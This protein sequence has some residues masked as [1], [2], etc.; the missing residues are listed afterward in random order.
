M[1]SSIVEQWI[2]S[3]PMALSAS[4]FAYVAILGFTRTERSW[5]RVTVAALLCLC[6]P[7]VTLFVA[8]PFLFGIGESNPRSI[9]WAIVAVVLSLP[10][11]TAQVAILPNRKRA[12]FE[13]LAYP[14]TAVLALA[15]PPTSGH[16]W[17]SMAD[18]SLFALWPKTLAAAPFAGLAAIAASG[19]SFRQLGFALV[20]VLAPL[21]VLKGVT[22]W[23]HG[24][25][26]RA[27]IWP[28]AVRSRFIG[29]DDRL[30]AWKQAHEGISAGEPVCIGDHWYRFENV[31][32]NG[33]GSSTS[34]RPGCLTNVALA[35]TAD[36]LGIASVISGRV[37]VLLFV[38][39]TAPENEL[40]RTKLT[41]AEGDLIVRLLPPRDAHVPAKQLAF[42][43][44][45]L[46]QFIRDARLKAP[47]NR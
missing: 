7:V 24:L 10:T 38:P 37:N 19:A 6:M 39:R 4:A 47:P 25:G 23:S 43:R 3:A 22:E 45:K 26:W 33:R 21:Y 46:R 18:V 8:S 28:A 35:T 12:G 29:A 41:I 2:F 32:V 9:I 16:P 34:Q 14:V 44:S 15:I 36:A 27:A 17:S 11:A 30:A 31:T 40:T 42:V 20:A 13:F 1:W 5:A